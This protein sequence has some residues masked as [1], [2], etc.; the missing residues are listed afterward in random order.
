MYASSNTTNSTSMTY[1]AR[2]LTVVGLG[3]ASVG[4]STNGFGVRELLISVPAGGGAGDG[5]N[6]I[7]AGT[8]LAGTMQTISFADSNG[9][10]WGLSNSSVLTASHNGL[11]SQSNQNVTAGNGGFAF[12]TLSFSNVNGFSFGTSAGSA[13]TG[14]YTVPTQSVQTLGFYAVS[15]TTGQS[16]SSTFDARTVSF[17]GAGIASVGYSGG[18]V[19]LSVPAPAAQSNQTLGLYAVGNTTG[20]SSSS[21]F[22]ARTLSFNGAGIAS[23]GYSAGSVIVSVPAGA[24]SPV[25]FSA[26]TTSNNLGSVVFSDSNG[27]SFGLNG[28]T[29]TASVAAGAG[30]ATLSGIL[31]PGVRML[32]SAISNASLII[33]ALAIE[34]DVSVD[35]ALFQILMSLST[36]SNSSHGG[37]ISISAALYTKN[38]STLSLITGSSGSQSWAWTNTSNNST[39]QLSNI[40]L[41]TVPMTVVA[42]PGVYY[43]AGW[44]RTSSANAN[45]YTG[46][47][48]YLENYMNANTRSGHMGSN[49]AQSVQFIGP[50]NGVFTAST[51]SMP[52]SIAI[53]DISHNNARGIYMVAFTNGTV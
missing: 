52:A 14:S 34:Q 23:V 42:T 3:I 30:G 13:I 50:V 28:S 22:D 49:S 36:S 17:H 27:V 44:I 51:T 43:L 46:S 16:S 9:I 48:V 4:F 20:Q 15:N 38:G 5:L 45:W 6:R 40:R 31:P 18:S 47:A 53:S 10:S 11:T 8:Q 35:R 37:T 39:Q 33:H 2:S 7:S 12:Q 41:F 24:P 19:I 1:D 26:G 21:T 32:N 25:N 29:I